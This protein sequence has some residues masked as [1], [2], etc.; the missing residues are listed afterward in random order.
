MVDTLGS[1]SSGGNP[2]GVQ[3]PPSAPLVLR[4]AECFAQ[5]SKSVEHENSR[6]PLGIYIDF[7]FCIARCSFC[8]FNIQGMREASS[9]RYLSALQKEISLHGESGQFDNRDIISLYLG[10][11]TPTLHSPETLNKIL[12]CCRSSFN[13]RE[14]AEITIEAH[15]ATINT[16]LLTEILEGGFNRLSIGIQS[17][18]DE[19]LTL[20]GRHHTKKEAVAAFDMARQAG[21]KNISLD[22]IYALPGQSL[23]D[24]EKSVQTTIDLDPEHLS[25]YG[26][27]IEEG[28][29]FYKNGVSLPAEEEQIAQYQFAQS[30]LSAAGFKQY[31]ISN[32]AKEGF[33]CKHNL[34]YWDRAETVGIG[35]SAHSYFNDAHQENTDSLAS[36]CEQVESGKIPISNMREVTSQ[37]AQIDR[38]IF[39]LRKREGIKRTHL[40]ISQQQETIFARLMKEDLLVEEDDRICLTPRGMLLADGVAMAFL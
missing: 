40:Q 32:F 19:M 38:I 37:E 22:L 10:G 9:Q 14:D 3:I 6:A 30:A 2:V 39:G 13:L 17:F 5:P 27:S 16:K 29:L 31:E 23:A 33:A 11:G 15:P 4:K 35:L 24:F 25:L 1:G 26:L 12:S 8:A 28:T 34:L 36:Y 7:P 21:F 18:S 20:L